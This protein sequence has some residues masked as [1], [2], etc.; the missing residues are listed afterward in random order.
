[1]FYGGVWTLE[2]AVT[3]NKGSQN[4]QPPKIGGPVR[5][6]T[7]NM[8]NAGPDAAVDP[9]L[10]SFQNTVITVCCR[11]HFVQT[12]AICTL[13]NFSTR[14]HGFCA[15]GLKNNNNDDDNNNNKNIFHIT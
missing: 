7:S 6:N 9:P 2:G 10:V 14:A 13:L 3:L 11:L 12:F 1:M 15:G 4:W 5:P 8:P